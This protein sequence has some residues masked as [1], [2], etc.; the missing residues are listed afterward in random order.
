MY[1]STCRSS[2]CMGTCR[3]GDGAR[4]PPG[5]AGGPLYS[6]LMSIPPK[7]RWRSWGGRL[8][9]M[10]TGLGCALLPV[11]GGGRFGADEVTGV[12]DCDGGISGWGVGV[13]VLVGFFSSLCFCFLRASVSLRLFTAWR[14]EPLA[15]RAVQ[16]S[17]VCS[18]WYLR[19]LECR[20]RLT[21]HA[22]AHLLALCHARII[23]FTQILSFRRRRRG[24]S[25]T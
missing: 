17:L 25:A 22:C 23:L 9:P 12:R 20:E 7:S 18:Q 3:G 13:D 21:F 2:C 8:W 24:S 5:M 14:I 15:H 19:N 16:E 6:P 10:S 4:M 11:A 1:P